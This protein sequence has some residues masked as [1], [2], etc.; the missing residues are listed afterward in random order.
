M[1]ILNNS[2]YWTTTPESI[3]LAANI[4]GGSGNTDL[5]D[6]IY[7]VLLDN[8]GNEISSTK[9]SVTSHITT[10]TG[11]DYNISIPVANNVHGVKISHNK[12][13]GYNV[14]YYSFSLSYTASAPSYSINAASNNNTWG[15]VSLSGSVITASP[16]AGYTYA[17]PAY[18]VSPANSATVAQ[19]G[20]EFTVTPSANTTVTINFAAI[21]TY[22]VTLGDNN[23]E[24]EE[25]YGGAGV[26]LPTRSDV[27]SYA[28]AGWSTMN[29]PSET[30]TA[31]TIIS[32][33]ETYYPTANITL[34]PVYTKT[35]AGGG[36]T[37]ETASVTV[38]E[39][40]TANSW[41]SSSSA[42]Q[43]SITLNSD[44]TAT[45][46]DG[47]NS[48][49]Y[50]SDWR[51]YQNET[52]K[53][54]ISTTSGELTSVTFTF[55]VSNT[56]TLN[57]NSSAITSG[58]AVNVSGTSAEFTVG[59]SGSATNGQVRITAISV[60]YDVT[61]GGTTY[62]WSAPVAA[63][64]ETPVIAVADN[65]F[66]FS[67]TATITCATDGATIKYSYDNSTW[68]DYSSALTIT[69]TTT[70]YAKA[71]KGDDESTVASVEVTKNL[72]TPT[73]TVSGNL[74]L[75]LD[76]ETNVSAGTLTA[77]VTYNNAAVAGATVTWSSSNTDIAT[78]DASGA[79]T[80]KTT[81]SVTFTAT[82]A[83]NSDYD[84]AT[85]TKTVTVVDSNVP[86]TTQ[87]NPYTVAQAL[88]AIQALPNNNA[89][90]EHYYISGIVS[91][92]FGEATGITSSSSKR[93]YISDD[94]TTNTQLLVYSGKG[95]NNVAFSSDDDLLIG[96]RVTIYGAIQN[97]NDDTPEIAYGNYIVSLTREKQDPTIVVNSTETVAYGST[98]TVDDS[99]IEG[100]TITVTSGNTN[101]A[102]VDGLV[103][104]PVAVGTTTITV[105]TE[106]TYHIMQAVRRSR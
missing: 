25:D 71:I 20:N 72:A 30:T 77:A 40:A 37:H 21:P 81:G 14:R 83:G 3:S 24:L 106:E 88:T 42:N 60:N 35:V 50:Y 10:N 93:Y 92:F 76:G 96:D 23:E 61:G 68:N 52:G 78:I 38:S 16:A 75:D 8:S 66:T 33:S 51:I 19:E 22:S 56:G 59:N 55:T 34:Y 45:C 101:V 13:S 104:T 70:I 32:T 103:I 18:S 11:D 87:Q 80:I 86:G 53:I 4:G 27:G 47:T 57:Y 44:V 2:A 15:T 64:V 105:A 69:E 39:Y 91:A 29:V 94:G 102:T 7:V 99:V 31:P 74:T 79:V 49:K 58:T 43:K 63:A 9:T 73:V 26:D 100:G 62:Y 82:Y 90:T 98:F 36:T 5:T 97:Y 85:G 89:T 1:Q 48:G 84:Q 17:S 54:T 41:G 95:L 65:P 67:T 12:Q 46:N 6:P 28:F